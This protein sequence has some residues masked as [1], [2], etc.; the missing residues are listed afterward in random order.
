MSNILVVDD[1]QSILNSFKRTLK[2]FDWNIHTNSNPLATL[3]DSGKSKWD[4]IISDYKMPGLNGI[5]FL[6]QISIENPDAILIIM[7]A[8]IDLETLTVALNEANI[9]RFIPKPWDNLVLGRTISEA[10]SHQKLLRE[11]KLLADQVRNQKSIIDKH[12]KELLRLEKESPGIT[13]VEFD[14]DGAIQLDM[15]P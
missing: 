15:D 1:E 11:N 14:E 13:K 3:A 6:K 2:K 7:S 8:N 5:E 4:V 9:H 12:E 10:L